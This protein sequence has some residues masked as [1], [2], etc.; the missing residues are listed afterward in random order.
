MFRERKKIR[1]LSFSKGLTL[2]ETLVY[3]AVLAVLIGIVSSFFV[4]A[5]HSNTKIKSM[6][7]VLD[8]ERR[9]IKIISSEIK[10]ARN[11][12]TP[13]SIFNSHPGQLSLETVKNLPEGE[14]K[15]YLDFYLCGER[16]CLKRESQAPI[17]LTSDE[18][19]V[20]NLVFTLIGDI[21]S[22]IKIDLK[23]ETADTSGRRERQADV[24]LSSVVSLRL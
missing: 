8:N 24:E 9:V 20:I 23:I 13:T 14:N 15:S 7:E 11:I 22:S 4:W 12:Y 21:S 2:I 10:E 16:V 6:H 1:T 18:V 19:K 3:V 17:V 5:V